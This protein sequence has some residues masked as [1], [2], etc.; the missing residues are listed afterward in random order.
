MKFQDQIDAAINSYSV[1]AG[2][3]GARKSRRSCYQLAEFSGTS[4]D[5]VQLFEKLSSII[6]QHWND[7][8]VKRSN[9]RWRTDYRKCSDKRAE[10]WLERAIFFQLRDLNWTYQVPTCSG[11]LRDG[12][13]RRRSIDLVHRLS[14]SDF[15]FIELKNDANNPFS[16]AFELL[17]Y[18]ALYLFTRSLG[19]EHLPH[20]T[21]PEYDLL[22]ANHIDLQVLAP[23]RYYRGCRL[24]QFEKTLDRATRDFSEC[25]KLGVTMT[26]SF[27]A[28]PERFPS[29]PVMKEQLTPMSLRAAIDGRRSAFN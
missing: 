13:G 16:A 10:V 11:L 24:V 23:Q 5:L 7:R 21:E 28:W 4:K 29:W 22:L 3:A 25:N 15:E 12:D 26:F 6:R 18:A 17:L 19:D 27:K 9:W 1:T 2:C 8:P 20:C 14:P